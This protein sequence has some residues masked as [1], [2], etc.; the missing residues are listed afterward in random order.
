ML[1][2]SS[3]IVRGVDS[4]ILLALRPSRSGRGSA[5]LPLLTS[6]FRNR[7]HSLSFPLVERASRSVPPWS[8]RSPARRNHQLQ[9][10]VPEMPDTWLTSEKVECRAAIEVVFSTLST[11]TMYQEDVEGFPACGGGTLVGMIAS[12]HRSWS[13]FSRGLPGGGHR[14]DPGP[15]PVR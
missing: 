10:R 15:G 4:S 14:L 12:F 8:K 3:A 1:S 5:L 9:F 11:I 2:P 6:R 13:S 7:Y